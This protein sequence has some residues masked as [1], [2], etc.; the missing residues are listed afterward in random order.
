M[1]LTT[2]PRSNAFTPRQLAAIAG[3]A[4]LITSA[5]SFW[6]LYVSSTLV[7]AGDSARTAAN[8]VAH[9]ERF[10]VFVLFDLLQPVGCIV[11]NVALYELLAPVH[12]SLA[13]LAAFWRLAESA[14]YG[15][16]IVNSLVVLSLLTNAEYARAFSPPELHALARLFRGAHATGFTI[17]MVFLGLGSTI[18]MILLI[19]SRYVPRALPL[20]VLAAGAVG[21]PFFLARL[22]APALVTGIVAAVRTLPAVALA[23]LAVLFAPILLCE[24]MLGF[25]L[26]VKGVRAPEPA[27]PLRGP[28]DEVGFHSA[29]PRRPADR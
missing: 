27:F 12:R 24:V 17:A 28:G 7:V 11:L 15:A 10:R 6:N 19:R 26:V 1:S 5:A 13:R 14:V 29:D 20:C 22:V 2:S 8:I 3:A 21:I 25:W 18:Y 23:S 16:I 4:Y 9:A